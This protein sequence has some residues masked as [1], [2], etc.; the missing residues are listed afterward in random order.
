MGSILSDNNSDKELKTVS[1]VNVKKYMGKWYEVARKPFKYESNEATNI[2]A[3]YS[4]RDDGWINVLNEEYVYG[5]HKQSLG[6]AYAL[7]E[8]NSKLRVTF[9]Y[10]F[11]GDYNIILLDPLYRY[12]VVSDKTGT[13]LWILSR[14][15]V[16]PELEEIIK[17]LE[18]MNINCSDLIYCKHLKMR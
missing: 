11:F 2:T 4:L 9:T 16:L 13:L 10:F 8:T 1:N 17:Q 3:T 15:K 6:E 7:D 14:K 5:M 12:S 18:E